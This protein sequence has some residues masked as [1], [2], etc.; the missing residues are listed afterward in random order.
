[1]RRKSPALRTPPSRIVLTPRSL[2][3]LAHVGG[4]ALVL[5]RRRARRHPQALDAAEPVDQLLGDSLAEVVLVLVRDSCRRTAA[6]RSKD[7]S[8]LRRRPCRLGLGARLAQLDRALPAV[9]LDALEAAVQCPSPDS[10]PEC[11]S[12]APGQLSLMPRDLARG[13]PQDGRHQRSRSSRRETA[14]HP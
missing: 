13:V 5:E 14:A 7:H 10:A 9:R 8:L 12:C 4:L 2:T 3:D 11:R 6:R 1:M